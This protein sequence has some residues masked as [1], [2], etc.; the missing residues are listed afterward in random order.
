[1]REWYQI[2]TTLIPTPNGWD[3]MPGEQQSVAHLVSGPDCRVSALLVTHVL[4]FR[5][6]FPDS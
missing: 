3:P 6:L 1:M 4:D 5:F 2:L